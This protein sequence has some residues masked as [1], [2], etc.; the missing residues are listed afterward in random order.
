MHVSRIEDLVKHLRW[1][2]F[3][4]IVEIAGFRDPDLLPGPPMVF[5]SNNEQDS[6]IKLR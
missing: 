6:V 2:F 5:E 4:K 3:A 1:N